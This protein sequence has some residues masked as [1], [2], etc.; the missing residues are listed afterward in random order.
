MLLDGREGELQIVVQSHT[1]L[2]RLRAETDAS[3]GDRGGLSELTRIVA[4]IA[5]VALKRSADD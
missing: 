1:R 5:G 2:M 3:S 4:A